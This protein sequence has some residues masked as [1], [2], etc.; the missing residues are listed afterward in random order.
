V[1]SVHAGPSVALYLPKSTTPCIDIQVI[2]TP[3]MFVLHEHKYI[4]AGL[5]RTTG[6][7]YSECWEDTVQ[8][9]HGHQ[10]IIVRHHSSQI[11]FSHPDPA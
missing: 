2:L 6:V 7:A 11:P 4:I 9:N 1:S 8:P 10:R 5:G 3:D